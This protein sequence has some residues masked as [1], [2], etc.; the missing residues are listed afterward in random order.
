VEAESF[1]N[2]FVNRVAPEEDTQQDDDE[3]NEIMEKIDQGV[4]LAE[5]IFDVLIPDALEYYLNLN[6]D[7]YDPDM[8]GDDS[9]EDGSGGDSDEDE[10]DK[11]KG[12]KKDKKPRK[13]S[14]GGEAKPA[15]DQKEC[16]QQ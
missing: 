6:D 12:G 4:N 14:K 8:M 16:K 5:D 1:F 9:D 10:G 2:A 11:K 7:L 3:V 15:E 13:G